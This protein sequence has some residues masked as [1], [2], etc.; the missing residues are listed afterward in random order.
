MEWKQNS[1]NGNEMKFQEKKEM[2]NGEENERV[3]EQNIKE[4]KKKKKKK[5]ITYLATILLMKRRRN[6]KRKREKKIQSYSI[7]D[8]KRSVLKQKENWK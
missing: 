1:E 8:I 3:I 2:W 5:S 6:W 4:K 7:V